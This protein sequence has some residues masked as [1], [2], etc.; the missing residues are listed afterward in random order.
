MIAPTRLDGSNPDPSKAPDM[1]LN[2]W[3][4]G[5][6]C[7]HFYDAVMMAW[8]AADILP[9]F[10]PGVGGPTCGSVASPA[11]SSLAVSSGATDD[12]DLIAY[13]SGRGPSSCTGEIKPEVSAPGVDIR[14]SFNDGDYYVWSGA[15]V[16]TAHLAGTAAL[17]MAADPSLSIDQATEIVTSTAL[18]I[19]DLSCGGT[20]CPDGANNV[21]GW[22]RIDAYEAVS[23]TLGVED[24]LPW[25][26]EMPKGGTLAAGQGVAI[27]VT[28]DST[29]LAEGVYTGRLE[30]ASDDPQT[31]HVLVPVT[32]TVEIPCL[33]AE[34]ENVVVNADG[35][36]ASFSAQ[37]TG[38]EPIAY[39]WDFGSFG[40]FNEPS[41]I[42]DFGV[43]GSYTGTLTVE[44]CDGVGQDMRALTV[45]VECVTIRRVY[46]PLIVKGF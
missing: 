22:G 46:V 29:G 8:R 16:A 42:V 33:P 19:E 40:V 34:V 39:S 36:V 4:T 2:M 37:V 23:L 35:C 24:V 30:V 10:T 12:S 43:T 28:F 26:D 45:D 41:P 32:L 38:T 5:G 3:G 20:P 17:V 14:S 27:D 25:L 44:N 21:Y 31:P 9:I 6:T 18:C 1:V 15:A 7:D 13:F 11:S